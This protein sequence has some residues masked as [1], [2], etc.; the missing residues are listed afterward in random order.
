[1]TLPSPPRTYSPALLLPIDPRSSACARTWVRF[2]LKA[3]PDDQ[4]KFPEHDLQDVEYNAALILDSVT[5]G[6]Y[7]YYRPAITAAR[8]YE[9]DPLLLRSEG[10]EGWSNTRR[11]TPEIVAAW[12]AQGL[13]FDRLI[14][15]ALLPVTSGLGQAQVFTPR[16]AVRRTVL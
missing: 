3:Q 2:F 10:A 7:I 14:P 8:L 11:S 6:T 9:G 12:L 1:M 4:G 15:V 13:A 16:S 5:D